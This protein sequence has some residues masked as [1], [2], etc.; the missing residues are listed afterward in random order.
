MFKASCILFCLICIGYYSH[1]QT[2]TVSGWV[3]DSITHFPISNGT[4]VNEKSRA[5]YK[6]DVNG[7]FTMK[8]SPGDML[9]ASA[10]DYHSD[11]LRYSFLSTD[12]ITIYLSPTGDLLP[13]VTVSARYN[14]Y[15]LD[16]LERR[17]TFD[18]MRGNALSTISKNRHEGFGL[19]LNLDRLTKRKYKDKRKQEKSFENTEEFAYSHYRYPPSM[20]AY[21]SGLRGDTLRQFMYEH[22]PS[23]QWLRQHTT[24]E[25]VIYYISDHLKLYRERQAAK[26]H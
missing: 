13:N 25:E 3:K 22:T 6:T 19:V 1:A 2:I 16:S 10:P 4:L 8:L 21:Y 5:V 18:L 20:V 11:T 23:Y 17:S 7:L 24:N 15:Q 26:L 12:T 9:L 14:K